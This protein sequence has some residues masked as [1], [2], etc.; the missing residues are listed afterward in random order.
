MLLKIHHLGKVYGE[1]DDATH[2]IGE[3]SFGVSEGEFVCVVGPSG[4][5]KTTLLKCISGL[6]QPTQGQ[7]ALRDDAISGP[8]ET[9]ALVFQEYGRSLL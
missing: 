6:L 3:L 7:V 4:C 9:L 2:A 5:G 8:P 1:G